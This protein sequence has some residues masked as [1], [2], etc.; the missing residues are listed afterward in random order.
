MK[1]EAPYGVSDPNASYIN[2]NPST[3]T[4][5]SIPPAASIENP[6]REVVNFIGASGLTPTDADL[7]QLAKAVQNGQVTTAIDGG[8]PNFIAITPT[9]AIAGLMLGMRIAI[10]VAHQNTGPVQINTSGLG[11]VP[12]VHADQ[13]PLGAWEINPNQ[14]I[15]AGFDGAKWQL[16]TGGNGGGL[17]VMTA[18]RTVYIDPNIGS[19]SAYDGT[20]ATVS[21]T[22]GP[23]LTLQHAFN[24]MAT[25]NQLGYLFTIKC[26]DGNYNTTQMVAA[27]SPNGTG[28]VLLKGNS[29]NPY[30]V[31]MVNVTAG[32]TLQLAAGFWTIDGIYFQSTAPSGPDVGVALWA[33]TGCTVWLDAIAF[34]AAPAYQCLMQG[35]GAIIFVGPVHLYGSAQYCLAAFSGGSVG[36]YPSPLPNLYIHNNLNY[37]GAFAMTQNNASM[38]IP[39]NYIDYT[40]GTVTGVRYNASGNGVISTG[41]GASFLP[42]SLPGVTASGGQYT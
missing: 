42:G 30:N 21:G 37:S 36:N 23:F 10:K 4:M 7:N 22:S 8:T 5:G 17:I 34:G 33:G 11:W 28:G 31:K 39:Y 13:S 29:A 41:R 14:L 15:I 24:V 12:L 3:G 16:L 35:N 38:N 1:Y 9:P 18:P 20:S 40:G 26:A 6:Q 19:D 27:P 2:G 25:F 32:S